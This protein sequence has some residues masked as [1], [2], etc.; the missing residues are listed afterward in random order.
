MGF[1]WLKYEKLYNLLRFHIAFQC[2]AIST[3]K[4][5]FSSFQLNSNQK[6]HVQIII[7]GIPSRCCSVMRC[8]SFQNY[9]LIDNLL[10]SCVVFY[11][12]SVTAFLGASKNPSKNNLIWILRWWRRRLQTRQFEWRLHIC[13]VIQCVRFYFYTHVVSTTVC[14]HDTKSCSSRMLIF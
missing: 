5:E 3:A 8:I 2:K 1:R 13:G 6:S 4:N 9:L 7:I 12:A 14:I 10:I 11:L